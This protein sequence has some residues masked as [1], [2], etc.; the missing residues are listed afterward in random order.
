MDMLKPILSVE[1]LIEHMKRKGIR[2]NIVSEESA[3]AFITDRTYYMKLS[4]Y[5]SNYPKCPEGSS[6]AGQYQNLEFAY[7]QELSTIDMHLRYYILQMCLDIEHALKVR[8]VNS[9]T[10]DSVLTEEDGY[11]FVNDFFANKDPAKHLLNSIRAHK[12]G[13]YCKDLIEKYY[14]DFP[15][16]VLAEVISFGDIVRLCSFYDDTRK[17]QRPILVK[18]KFI[19][20]VRDF[21]NASAHSNCLLNKIPAQAGQTKQ[22]DS[23]IVGFIKTVPGIS[24]ESRAKYLNIRFCYNICVLFYVYSVYLPGD[25]QQKR[26]AELKEFMENRVCK[27]RKYF[28][29]NPQLCGVYKFLKKVVDGLV[30]KKVKCNHN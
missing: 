27:N 4:A 23:R 21:R 11:R 20:V 9:I 12:A 5:R 29:N 6:R 15:I 16:W 14:P 17:P 8:L 3:K 25:V 26:F 18:G 10:R 22:P 24:D 7:L 1:E 13:E 30:A 2:F 28:L 19:N